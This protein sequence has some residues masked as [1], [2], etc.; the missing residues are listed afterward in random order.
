MIESHPYR[1]D[2]DGLRALAILPVVFF[3][4]DVS[5]F[6]GGFVGV[7]VFFV[8]SGYLIASIIVRQLDAGDFSLA[9]FYERRV[10]RILPALLVMLLVTALLGTLLLYP[11]EAKDYARSL[12]AATLFVSSLFFYQKSGYFDLEAGSQP[13]LHTWSLSVEEIFYIFFPLLMLILWRHYRRQSFGWVLIVAVLSFGGAA[14]ALGTDPSS[15][16][17][18][19][20]PPFR[21]WELMVGVLVA[22]NPWRLS[23][24]MASANLLSLVGLSLIVLPVFFYSSAT[25][26]PGVA[27]LLPCAGAALILLAG[28]RH[29]SLVGRLLSWRPLVFLGLISYSLY[30]WHW[31]VLVY[32]R[33]WTGAPL[34]PGQAW[35]LIGLSLSLAVLSWRFIERPFRGR[36]GILPGRRVF[37][38]AGLASLLLVG[39]GLYGEKTGGWLGRYPPELATILAAPYDNRDPRQGECLTTREDAEGCRYG[40]QE[41]PPVMALWGDSFAAVYAPVLGEAARGQGGSLLSLTMAACPPAF[42]WQP[43]RQSW[44][45]ACRRFQT[46]ALERLSATPGIH[47]V[48]LAANFHDY[49]HDEGGAALPTALRGATARLLTAGKRVVLTYPVPRLGTHVPN[50]LADAILAGEDPDRVRRPLAEFL[51]DHRG[52]FALLAS[53]P[54]AVGLIRLYPHEVLCPEGECRFYSEGQPWYYDDAHL[55]LTGAALVRPLFESV[56]GVKAQGALSPGEEAGEEI[57]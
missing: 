53:V 50:R 30:L 40:D 3:H 33:I 28:Q 29:P 55:S 25:V 12:V 4:A 16:A 42:D 17:A 52:V 37:V 23:R 22:L 15:R 47:T 32:G 49:L 14:L 10:R 27:A 7:D 36:S 5:G 9:K 44:R 18:F 43:T 51:N 24:G 41:A 34:Q 2:I 38:A 20:L 39:I 19:F 1:A 56:L 57:P 8:I 45:D 6:G 54:D 35:L 13:L 21:A 26:F 46:F 48:I 11:R 31:P